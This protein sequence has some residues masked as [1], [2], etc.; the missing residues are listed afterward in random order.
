MLDNIRSLNASEVEARVGQVYPDKGVSLLLYKDARCDMTILD[1]CVGPMGWQRKHEFKDGKLYCS[2]G[3]W[4]DAKQE[5]VWKE[6]VGTESNMEADKGQASDA[7]KRACV[8]WGIGREL[9]TAPFIFVPVGKVT[10]VKGR[11]GKMQCRD[12]FDVVELDT[13]DTGRIRKIAI[14]VKG[15]RVFT[16]GGKKQKP[17]RDSSKADV[18]RF[19]E[20]S[21]RMVPIMG[22]DS[23]EDVFEEL[24][25]RYGTTDEG[26][27]DRSKMPEMTKWMHLCVTCGAMVDEEG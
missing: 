19:M 9:Y 4:D 20:L 16:W 1:E 25:R 12:K 17:K 11:N 10:L 15:E 8:N 14:D 27:L 22:A 3:I 7:F 18:D 5:W 6:D 24:K 21:E 13:D 26:N 23:R 2:V